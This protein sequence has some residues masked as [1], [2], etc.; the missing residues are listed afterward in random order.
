MWFWIRE[1][2][3]WILVLV[4]LYLLRVGL[5]FVMDVE[6]PGIVEAAILFFAALGVMRAG[7]LLIRISAAA[8]A[9]KFD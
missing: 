3:G 5:V 6:N 8:R 9:C 2:V 7:I 1:I 4:A